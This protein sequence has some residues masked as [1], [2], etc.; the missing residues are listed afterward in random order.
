MK[1]ARDQKP[2]PLLYAVIS[3]AVSGFVRAVLAEF[4]KHL[5]L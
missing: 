3:G 4:A 2:K 5:G 1:D